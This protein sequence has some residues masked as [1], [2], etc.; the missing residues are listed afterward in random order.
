MTERT[1]RPDKIDELP[2]RIAHRRKVALRI[3][4]DHPE[5]AADDPSRT[6]DGPGSGYRLYSGRSGKDPIMDRG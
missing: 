5:Y 3:K 1:R 4:L 6:V 2:D